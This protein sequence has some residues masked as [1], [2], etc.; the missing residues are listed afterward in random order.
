MTGT[1]A[2]HRPWNEPAL[3]ISEEGREGM[4]PAI[5]RDKVQVPI[6]VEIHQVQ[7]RLS[8]G[9]DSGAG[10]ERRPEASTETSLVITEENV[11]TL[12][13]GSHDTQV[14]EA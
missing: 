1:E 5:G 4:L 7:V 3:T 10:Y 14:R 13:A 11:Y 8:D 12:P 2:R 9:V 6:L